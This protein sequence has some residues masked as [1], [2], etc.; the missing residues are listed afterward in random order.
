[1]WAKSYV[2]TVGACYY[3]S[4]PSKNAR[5]ASSMAVTANHTMIGAPQS[6]SACLMADVQQ[7]GET[8][9]DA[10]EL[11]RPHLS[12]RSYC[13]FHMRVRIMKSAAAAN[14]VSQN[15]CSEVI[16]AIWNSWR[17]GGYEFGQTLS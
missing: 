10:T 15:T 6:S 14:T 12:E 11:I 16:R 4:G 3:C 2:E 9:L 1:M 17:S 13:H 5:T 8:C 7:C